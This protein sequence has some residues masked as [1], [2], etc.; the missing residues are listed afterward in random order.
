MLPREV[1]EFLSLV[2]FETW[3]D[4]LLFWISGWPYPEQDAGSYDLL[5]E[6]EF[7]LYL[8]DLQIFIAMG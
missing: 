2:G 3:L 1:V 6:P 7:I 5:S 4:S 8:Y